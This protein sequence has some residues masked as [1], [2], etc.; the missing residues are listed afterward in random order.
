MNT[1]ADAEPDRIT[2]IRARLQLALSPTLLEVH[3]ESAAHR[4]H[5]GVAGGGGHFRVVISSPQFGN[6]NA[7]ARHR[8]V[9]GALD[10][11]MGSAIHALTVEI[12]RP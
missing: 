12:P 2:A 7:V 1:G 3:D 9:Y 10:D 11:L 5:A 8:M 6:Q 4:G